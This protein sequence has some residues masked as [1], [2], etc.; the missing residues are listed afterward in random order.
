MC[1]LELFSEIQSHIN[2]IKIL[3]IGTIHEA[4]ETSDN[5]SPAAAVIGGVIGVTLLL[6]VLVVLCIFFWRMIRSSCKKKK[7]YLN[8]NV[9]F[10][11]VSS[12]SER[13]VSDSVNIKS[14]FNAEME[15]R[16]C[17]C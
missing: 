17:K 9:R 7:K 4:V 1:D 13:Y 2:F 11:K 15:E 6:I 3:I 14:K 5:T 10:V 12:N 8:D 16:I